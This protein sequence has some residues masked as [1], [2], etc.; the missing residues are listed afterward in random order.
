MLEELIEKTKNLKEN[1]R[2]KTEDIGLVY[3]EYSCILEQ[4][5]SKI[6]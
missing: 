2:L 3:S 6:R 1:I 4:R 5:D